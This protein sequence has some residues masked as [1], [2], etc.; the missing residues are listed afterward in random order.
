MVLTQQ[1]IELGSSSE[2]IPDL[3]T[4]IAGEFASSIMAIWGE[5]NVIEYLTASAPQRHIWHAALSTSRSCL[6]P[7]AELRT[8]L[9]TTRRKQVILTAYGNTPPGMI[10]LLSKLEPRAES[11]AFYRAVHSA[12]D[13]GDALSR[14]LH[15]SRTIDRRVVFGIASLPKDEI[16]V[17]MATYALSNGDRDIDIEELTWLGRRVTSFDSSANALRTISRSNNPILALRN[18][19]A[20][21]PFPEPPWAVPELLPITSAAELLET[22]RRLGNCLSDHDQFYSSCIDVHDGVAFYYR[23]PPHS[24]LLLK[25]TKF[26]SLGWYLDEC[27]GFRNRR[28]TSHEIE[29]I[30]QVVSHLD[31]VWCRRL[32]YQMR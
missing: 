31:G 7:I 14:N 18:A 22:A 20:H 9:T 11:S 6:P 24:D 17:R 10:S 13:R 32:G 25:F 8:W 28:P 29:H 16:A 2:S 3:I 15:H 5:D 27:R 26:A 23:T 12:L 4:Y 21:L 19:I 30:T 1:E